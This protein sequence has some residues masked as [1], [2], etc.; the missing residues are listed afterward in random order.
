MMTSNK[1]IESSTSSKE[2]L[3]LENSM[4]AIRTNSG[5][6]HIV[7][8][9]EDDEKLGLCNVR[10]FFFLILWYIFSAFTLFLNKYILA[11]LKG[12]PAVLGKIKST[13]IE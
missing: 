6:K 5:T 12:D 3:Y 9:H 11:T 7:K 13:C 10:A 1:E 8:K 2:A 4:D